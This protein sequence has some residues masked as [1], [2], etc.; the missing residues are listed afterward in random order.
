MKLTAACNVS[1]ETSA[2]FV[3]LEDLVRKWNPKINLV[4]KA[5]LVDLRDRHIADSAQLI[6]F[7]E[8]PDHWVDLGSGGGF[9]ALVIAILAQERGWRTIVT[10]IESDRRKCVFL[11]TAVRELELRAN[12][13]AERIENAAPQNADV[14]SARALTELRALLPYAQ[15]HLAPGGT[16]LFPKGANW[17]EEEAK[18]R[19]EWSFECRAVASKTSPDAAILEIKEIARA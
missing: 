19:T 5:S 12:V 17:R 2:K 4:S 7:V 8:E 6:D 14:V 18:A 3:F 13:I 9:P 10:M 15:L 1:R 11:R 16:A